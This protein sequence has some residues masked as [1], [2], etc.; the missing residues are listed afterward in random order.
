MADNRS[1]YWQGPRAEAPEGVVRG[2]VVRYGG[3][4]SADDPEPRGYRDR[5]PEQS[6]PAGDS[7]YQSCARYRHP[8]VGVASGQARGRLTLRTGDDP[9]ATATALMRSA[10]GPRFGVG[11][12]AACPRHRPCQKGPLCGQDRSWRRP[13]R[14]VAISQERPF[15]SPG[16]SWRGTTFPCV[17]DEALGR[18]VSRGIGCDNDHVTWQIVAVGN[19]FIETPGAV[20]QVHGAIILCHDQR[21]AL[22][23]WCY[24]V[25]PNGHAA[26]RI[27]CS[28]AQKKAT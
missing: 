19:P 22:M 3:T 9:P 12:M 11:R 6:G 21:A 26:R 20:D 16:V 18:R 5:A 24:A 13:A 2:P 23:D 10:R 27:R 15:G 25:M 14:T 17:V 1:I 7:K 4:A 28:L 8:N